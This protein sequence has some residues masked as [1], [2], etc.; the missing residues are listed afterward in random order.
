MLSIQRLDH[1]ETI[2]NNHHN[3]VQLKEGLYG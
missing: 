1:E 2:E 3:A